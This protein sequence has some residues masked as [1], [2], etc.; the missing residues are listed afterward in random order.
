MNDL[1]N[2]IL[3][4][5]I[6]EFIKYSNVM[7]IFWFIYL[8][9]KGFSI[10]EVA[11]LESI[12]H[13]TSLVFESP[14]GVIADLLGRKNTR[15]F[16]I[17]FHIFYLF[18]LWLANSY[19]I[20]VL[21]F[22]IAAISYN[23]ESGSGT[24][25]VY[26]TLKE[27]DKES[28]FIKIESYRE[29]LIRIASMLGNLLGGLLVLVSYQLAIGINIFT[30][31]FAIVVA[32]TF[33][34]T[35]IQ[36]RHQKQPF[37]FAFIQQYRDSVALFQKN[38]PLLFAMISFALISTITAI[39]AYYATV[40]WESLWWSSFWIGLCF[41]I[42][43]ICAAIGAYFAHMIEK[44][45]TIKKILWINVVLVTVGFSLFYIPFFSVISFLLLSFL[46]G[47][48][49]VSMNALINRQIKS[50]IRATVLSINSMFFSLFMV[51]FFPLF[52]YAIQQT[53][54]TISFLGFGFIWFALLILIVPQSIVR[55]KRALT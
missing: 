16:G 48:L 39:L 22:I 43:G 6:F 55:S 19:W 18:G 10:V 2:N 46:D 50:E 45:I 33:K 54:F 1:K 24:A 7:H 20:A 27:I 36:K 41:A 25:F 4:N 14:T 8:L 35:T 13:L 40:I 49:Y 38:L 32:L 15:I 53:N 11:L 29:S 12:F 30:Y 47:G 37:H 42:A 21:A 9:S 44:K 23:L 52:G 28:K 3:K 51:A 5:Y 26:D 17:I 31:F 34:E